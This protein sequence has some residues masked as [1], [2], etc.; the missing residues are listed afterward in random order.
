[1]NPRSRNASTAIS[2]KDHTSYKGLTRNH[3]PY[4]VFAKI[5]QE[6][7]E[8]AKVALCEAE[9]VSG[10][11]RLII[12]QRV[13][14]ELYDSASDEKKRAVQQAIEVEE[15]WHRDNAAA[16]APD[17]YPQCVP[18]SVPNSFDSDKPAFFRFQK[19]LPIVLD[20]ARSL[21]P[22]VVPVT[23]TESPESTCALFLCLFYLVAQLKLL[24]Y[25][26]PSSLADLSGR[27][28]PVP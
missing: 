22:A 23:D 16:T 1:M 19:Q 12:W 2:K 21:T 20:A 18:T 11:E 10:R 25:T 24:F 28:R 3:K 7:V 17:Q 15:Q 6:E 27:S 14:K 4:E 9:G 26:C 8:K 13:S 5:Y